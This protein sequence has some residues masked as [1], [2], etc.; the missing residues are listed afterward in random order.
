MRPRARF[1]AGRF[2]GDSM[3][4]GDAADLW[5]IELMLAGATHRH[6]RLD[7]VPAW[8]GGEPHVGADIQQRKRSEA[9]QG[10]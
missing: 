8:V 5:L 1:R 7:E 9:K 2:P 10:G 6:A 3:D 4:P